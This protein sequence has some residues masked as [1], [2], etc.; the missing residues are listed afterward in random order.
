M[1]VNFTVVNNAAPPA[2]FKLFATATGP[3]SIDLD[4]RDTSNNETGFRILHSTTGTSYQ[5]LTTVGAGVTHYTHDSL[6]P[7]SPHFYRVVAFNGVGDSAN[8]SASATALPPP[9]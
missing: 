1:V 6:T 3:S 2:P 5:T 7:N 4:W 8:S 9:G